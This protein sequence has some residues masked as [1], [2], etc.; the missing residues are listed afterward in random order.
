MI[1]I[2]IDVVLIPLM[3]IG[4]MACVCLQLIL[5]EATTINWAIMAFT[6]LMQTILIILH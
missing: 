4:N 2:I 6:F 1:T 3:E 5:L